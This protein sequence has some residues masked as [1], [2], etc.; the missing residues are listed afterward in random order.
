MQSSS[1]PL[2]STHVNPRH[3]RARL[4]PHVITSPRNH[5]IPHP[6]FIAHHSSFITSPDP[7]GPHR[8]GKRTWFGRGFLATPCSDVIAI[9]VN[10][11]IYAK[12][13]PARK[14]FFPHG[15]TEPT[16]AHPR[17][18]SWPF[19]EDLPNE[20][21]VRHTYSPS[22]LRACVPAVPQCLSRDYQT[23]PPPSPMYRHRCYKCYTMLPCAKRTPLNQFPATTAPKPLTARYIPRKAPT[24]APPLGVCVPA[25]LRASY[26]IT[27][28]TQS[29][30]ARAN[31]APR[32]PPTANLNTLLP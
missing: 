8:D 24:S 32:W 6:Q 18:T 26:G 5:V 28:R 19:V 29:R 23:N 31:R 13:R 15:L 12:P 21:G 4:L 3:L 7:S 10:T 30:S 1:P 14:L 17:A 20:P 16:H 2:V 11:A 22:C 27:K 9:I 25:C